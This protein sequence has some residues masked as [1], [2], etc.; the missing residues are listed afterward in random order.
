VSAQCAEAG[1]EVAD[2]RPTRIELDCAR[3]PVRD[4]TEVCA[5]V[6]D[7]VD[8]GR[9]QQQAANRAFERDQAEG[10]RARRPRFTFGDLAS[11]VPARP[12]ARRA[13]LRSSRGGVFRRRVAVPVLQVL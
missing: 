2:E 11:L 9:Q 7:E 3:E 6:S 12:R 13:S 8:A 4:R 10:D 1:D 5:R